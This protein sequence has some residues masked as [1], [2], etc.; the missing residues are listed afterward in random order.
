MSN[1]ENFVVEENGC[2]KCGERHVDKL[3]WIMD[4]V[5]K[6]ATCGTE[7][8]PSTGGIYDIGPYPD[9]DDRREAYYENEK[10]PPSPVM[11]EG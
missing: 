9:I 11:K 1:D 8:S 5:V 7:Y 6:C 3:E 2:P 10:D 4:H